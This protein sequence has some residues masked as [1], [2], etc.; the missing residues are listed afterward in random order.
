MEGMAVAAPAACQINPQGK[1][2]GALSSA[3]GVCVSGGLVQSVVI[4]WNATRLYS[5]GWSMLA[6]LSQRHALSSKLTYLCVCV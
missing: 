1:H 4:P 3:V 2:S 6:A 5:Y